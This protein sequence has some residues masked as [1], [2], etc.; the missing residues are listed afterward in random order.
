MWDWAQKQVAGISTVVAGFLVEKKIVAINTNYSLH[1]LFFV[2][3][4]GGFDGYGDDELWAQEALL[5]APCSAFRPSFLFAM[6]WHI[7]LFP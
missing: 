7:V 1:V 4:S 2:H 3:G 6:K 5:G